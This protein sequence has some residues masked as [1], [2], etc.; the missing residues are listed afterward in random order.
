MPVNSI[1]WTNEKIRIIDQ[2]QLPQKLILL[3]I[4][5]IKQLRDAICTM[6]IRGA[7]AL[8]VA[9]AFGV[10]LGV[11]NLKGKLDYKTLKTEVEKICE[12]LNS[13]RPTAVNLSWATNRMRK[14]ME[15]N[16]TLPVEKIKEKLKEEAFRIFKE[17]REC[18]KAIGQRGASLLKNGDTVLTHCNAGALATAGYGTALAS[19]YRAKEEGK[20]I[21]VY[22]DETRPL[23][24]GARL[25]AWELLQEEIEVTLICDNMAGAVMKKGEIDKIIVGADRVTLNGDVANKIGTYS[26]AVLAKENKIP[27][28]VACPLSTIDFS[29]NSGEKIPIEIRGEKEIAFVCGRQFAPEGVKVYNPAFDVTPSKYVSAI[30]T[31]EGVH[32]PP[33]KE[34]FSR[35]KEVYHGKKNN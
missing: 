11:K 13:S 22:V 32:Y 17:D 35:L 4:E 28:Y 2:T 25:T 9:G 1:Q 3:D 10:L 21:K 29:L 20:K 8:G 23:L 18:N 12:Y 14:S 27:F 24:Q 31:E 30:I 6:Q 5:N 16:S 26:L 19:I 15:K 34:L 7:P 33:Y